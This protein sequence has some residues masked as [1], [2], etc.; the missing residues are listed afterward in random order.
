MASWNS[1]SWD[2]PSDTQTFDHQVLFIQ[3]HF[4]GGE[5]GVFGNQPDLV[6][7]TLEALDG[8]FLA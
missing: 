7:F 8:D 6:A 4:Y 3:V 1:G 2:R 5:L